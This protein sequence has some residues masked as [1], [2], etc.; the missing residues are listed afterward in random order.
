MAFSKET[1][2]A[3]LEHFFGK[4]VY[5]PPT[6]YVGLST[7]TGSSTS[8][9][10]TGSGYA[11]VSTTAADW[12]V[13]DIT[14]NATIQNTSTLQFPTATGSWG[15]VQEAVLYDALTGGNLLARADANGDKSITTDDVIIILPNK[16]SF[17]LF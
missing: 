5:T 7:T 14:G 15:T 16:L 8:S 6:I 2:G 9:E 11:R 4:S 13:M 17:I 1:A 12:S 10:V 3:L